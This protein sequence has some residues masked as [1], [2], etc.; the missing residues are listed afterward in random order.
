MCGT[1][2][3]ELIVDD[4]LDILEEAQIPIIPWADDQDFDLD[5]A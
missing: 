4:E 5:N 1:H 3:N 2:I